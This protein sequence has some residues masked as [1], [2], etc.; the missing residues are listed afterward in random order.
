VYAQDSIELLKTS[1]IDFEK[2]EKLGIDIRYFGEM[3]MMSGLVLNDD[4]TWVTFHSSF[5]FGYLLKT[6]TGGEL[7]A[8][9]S[10]FLELFHLY[11]PVVYDVKVC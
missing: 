11:F 7:P 6:L 1:G 10:G 9:E 4:V 3:M 8:D 5:D 2:F